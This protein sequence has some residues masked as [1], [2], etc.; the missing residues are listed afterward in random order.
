M[1]REVCLESGLSPVYSGEC[2]GMGRIAFGDVSAHR[3]QNKLKP[4][5]LVTGEFLLPDV[6]SAVALD[7]SPVLALKRQA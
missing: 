1:E 6:T 7:D 5:F 4:S 2:F 3:L